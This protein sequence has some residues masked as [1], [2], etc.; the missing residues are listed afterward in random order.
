MNM[1]NNMD[2]LKTELMYSLI[3]LHQ[4]KYDKDRI[5]DIINMIYDVCKIIFILN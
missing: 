4:L 2:K 5:M 1:D 3:Q